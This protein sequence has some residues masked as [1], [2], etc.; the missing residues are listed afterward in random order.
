[1]QIGVA[2]GD[3]CVS[4]GPRLGAASGGGASAEE[5][6]DPGGAFGA[7]VGRAMATEGE[8]GGPAGERLEASGTLG[9]NS[10][11]TLEATP[12]RLD[13]PLLERGRGE[14]LDS[15]LGR[16][17][18]GRADD[19][20][21]D[22]E[23]ERE[24]MTDVVVAFAPVPPPLS[25]VKLA[26]AFDPNPS[27]TTGDS[28]AALEGAGSSR[29]RTARPDPLFDSDAPARGAA[30]ERAARVEGDAQ[31]NMAFEWGAAAARLGGGAKGSSA[32]HRG[33][34]VG[35]E[36][37]AARSVPRLGGVS[38]RA[39]RESFGIG[40]EAHARAP[41]AAPPPSADA[42]VGNSPSASRVLGPPSGSS[43][44]PSSAVAARVQFGTELAPMIGADASSSTRSRAWRSSLSAASAPPRGPAAADDPVGRTPASAADEDEAAL[45]AVAR[46][47]GQYAAPYA[48]LELEPQGAPTRDPA[49]ASHVSADPQGEPVTALEPLVR[50]LDIHASTPSKTLVSLALPL[51]SMKE[52]SGGERDARTSTSLPSV[53]HAPSGNG[54]RVERSDARRVEAPNGAPKEAERGSPEAAP[55]PRGGASEIAAA[56][57]RPSVVRD[58]RE[59]KTREVGRA[60][61][62]DDG[63]SPREGVREKASAPD[64]TGSHRDSIEGSPAVHAARVDVRAVDRSAGSSSARGTLGAEARLDSARAE[65]QEAVEV[66]VSRMTLRHG[67]HAEALL[68]EVGRVAIHARAQAG[69]VDV[70]MTTRSGRF[71]EEIST[72]RGE[73]RDAFAVDP[74]KLGQLSVHVDSA[75]SPGIDASRAGDASTGAHGGHS[76]ERGSS[77][78]REGAPTRDAN[79]GAGDLGRE[80]SSEDSRRRRRVR[81]VL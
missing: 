67:M 29:A 75:P 59:E 44:V 61:L 53:A 73:L 33:T 43:V 24:L 40:S 68:P 62:R 13:A 65:R 74:I 80:N 8:R 77:S 11:R 42:H 27:P 1:M 46:R 38:D 5:P 72:H 41:G 30:L 45:G 81:F 18:G 21:T 34:L 37:A 36:P 69:R 26:L 58:H 57:E 2:L 14:A 15:A 32:L 22:E 47:L 71:A 70:D 35:L 4:A 66:N 78:S 49:S 60:L 3:V 16:A 55:A 51:S 79:T 28:A 50:A 48:A 31:A 19:D 12:P 39:R 23:G 6:A 52:A 63:N 76:H 20:A 56:H 64:L 9:L 10:P 25:P 7:A 17:L 54:P